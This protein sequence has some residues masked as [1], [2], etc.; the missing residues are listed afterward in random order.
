MFELI[1]CPL[2]ANSGLAYLDRGFLNGRLGTI[3]SGYAPQFRILQ[4]IASKTCAYARTKGIG[5][6][7][8]NGHGAKCL[9][10]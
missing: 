7:D 8:G 3:A 5:V 10:Y 2:D 1:F 9:G 4:T 6:Y